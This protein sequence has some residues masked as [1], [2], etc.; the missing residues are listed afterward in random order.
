MSGALDM[1]LENIIK[2]SK[3]TAGGGRGR[4]REAGGSS[5]RAP[6]RT[7]NRSA[8]YSSGKAPNSVWQHDMYS[9]AQA[10]G[11]PVATARASSIDIGT[12]L[13]ILNLEFG[14]SNEGIKEEEE[15]ALWSEA[16]GVRPAAFRTSMASLS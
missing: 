13:Y 15:A 10:G 8:P 14:V 12:K 1:S 16:N 6:N 9:T 11:F 5:R 4:G 3:K 7:A 2:S